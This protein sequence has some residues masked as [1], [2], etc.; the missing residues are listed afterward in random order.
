MAHAQRC[1]KP[2]AECAQPCALDESIPCSP[3]CKN[4]STDGIPASEECYECDAFIPEPPP[5]KPGGAGWVGIM[6]Y[7]I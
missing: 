4:L 7:Q 6:F 5:R 1:K 3:D 2:C